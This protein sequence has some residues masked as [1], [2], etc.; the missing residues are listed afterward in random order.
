[1][2]DSYALICGYQ[3]RHDW[4]CIYTSGKWL[5]R[6]ILSEHVSQPIVW[7]PSQQLIIV[8]TKGDGQVLDAE[9]D[10]RVQR[11][12]IRWPRL[13]SGP[14]PIANFEPV[15]TVAYLSGLEGPSFWGLRYGCFVSHCELVYEKLT[16]GH[17]YCHDHR[18]NW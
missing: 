5:S 17:N 18:R 2:R 1:M 3:K 14:G 8:R 9:Q 15:H 6:A 4:S 12:S 7:T 13:Q 16:G 10:L 11:W